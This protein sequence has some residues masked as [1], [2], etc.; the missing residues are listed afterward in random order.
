[1][2][3]IKKWEVLEEKDIS[4]SKWFPL[5]VH[6]VRLPDG[7]VIEDYYVSRLGDVAMVVA[8]TPERELVLARQYKH[9]VQEVILE[10]PA[11]R[12]GKRT[13]RE[14][15]RKE[16]QE[17]TGIVADELISIGQVY[18]APPK[19]STVTHG[20]L[21]KG[22]RVQKGQAFDDTEDIELVFV[23]VRKLDQKIK[24]GEIRASDTI[25]LIT[26]ARLNSPELFE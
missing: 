2:R 1:M 24:S 9:G 6:K 7:K 10:L 16:L 15:A 8:I 14:A 23:P 26:L 13:P 5:F 11:G 17:E 20:F 12:V 21:L 19:D 18:V 22:A 25:A 3:K 4:P